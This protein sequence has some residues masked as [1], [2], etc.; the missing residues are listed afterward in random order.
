MKVKFF[1]LII[2][3][4]LFAFLSCQNKKVELPQTED[5]AEIDS[6]ASKAVEEANFKADSILKK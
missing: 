1:S 3:S 6:I 4:V 5:E 2:F